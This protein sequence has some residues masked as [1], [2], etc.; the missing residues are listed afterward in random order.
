[1]ESDLETA[2]LLHQ[3]PLFADLPPEALLPV[4]RLSSYRMLAPDERLFEQGSF[5]DALF[6]VVDGL[7]RIEQHG[8]LLARLGKGET[9]GEMAVLDWQP[10]SASVVAEQASTLLRVERNDLIDLLQEEPA[11]LR[12]LLTLLSR[13]IRDLG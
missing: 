3:V 1:M 9:V 2:L 7:L 6:V 10:R 5:G 12:S 4:A 13:R 8:Q 11:L